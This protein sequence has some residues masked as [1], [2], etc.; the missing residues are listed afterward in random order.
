MKKIE[1]RSANWA[2]ACQFIAEHHR[3]H[4]P[5]TGWKFGVVAIFR[6]KIVGIATVGRPSSR[7]L[8]ARGYL[9]VTRTCTVIWGVNRELYRW[10]AQFAPICTYTQGS[11][12]GRS[13][14]A[15]GWR[16]TAY[17]HGRRSDWNTPAR[18]RINVSPADRIRWEPASIS[19]PTWPFLD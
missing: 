10:A 1:L 16:P 5:P 6:D 11:E 4:A 2:E 17:R 18:V 13:L 19:S 14:L 9:E 7:V 3:H 15:A 12:H 8:Q